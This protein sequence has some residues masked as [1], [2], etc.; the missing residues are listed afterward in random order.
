[1]SILA[2][3]YMGLNLKNPVILGSCPISMDIMKL[4]EAE[5]SG[6]SAVILKSLFEEELKVQLTG[7]V[8]F[9]NPESFDYFLSE[10]DFKYSPAN[11]LEHIREVKMALDIPVIASINCIGSKWWKDYVN[12]IEEYGADGLELNISYYSFNKDDNPRNIEQK[13][14]DLV[15]SIKKMVDIPVAVKIGYNFTSIPNLINQLKGAGADG[16]VLFNRYY[17][18]GIKL[19][20]PTL[21]RRPIRRSLLRRPTRTALSGGR[22]LHAPRRHLLLRLHR[23]RAARRVG[24]RP[25]PLRA[26]RGLPAGSGLRTR[27]RDPGHA[28]PRPGHTEARVAGA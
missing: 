21:P 8:K 13:Y 5:K 20:D 11:Y 3:E 26:G 2:S 28:G 12:G 9:E 17:K 19:D 7:G 18:C 6:I 10:C 16:V 14:I 4:K 22:A 27:R 23:G 24:F 1:M 15:Y 25:R